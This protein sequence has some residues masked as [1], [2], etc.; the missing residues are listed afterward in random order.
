V[1]Y[2]FWVAAMDGF[3]RK[4]LNL[5][6]KVLEFLKKYKFGL[7]FKHINQRILNSSFGIRFRKG[8]LEFD[9]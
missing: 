7:W 6:M 4:I 8:N 5:K 9:S 3:K 2:E 1:I